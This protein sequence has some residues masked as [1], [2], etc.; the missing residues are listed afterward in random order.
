MAGRSMLR[1][2][3][4]LMPKITTYWSSSKMEQTKHTL[5]DWHLE[6]I[7]LFQAFNKKYFNQYILPTK[8]IAY[9]NK[10]AQTVTGEKLAQLA[11]HVL[12]EIKD[13]KHTFTHFTK[14]KMRDFCYE[15]SSGLAIL[16]YKDYPFVL[17]LFIENPQSFVRPYSKGFEP[18]MFFCMGG[19]MRHLTGFTRI[20]N[21]KRI[22]KKLQT[23][24]HWKKRV[25]LP[26]KWFWEPRDNQYFTIEGKNIG[27]EQAIKASLP[28]VYAVICDAIE[29]SHFPLINQ[30][31]RQECLDIARFV[32]Y[33]LD[34]H[35]PNFLLEKDTG[36]LVIIDT[37][38]FP[39]L[40]GL[41]QKLNAK[42]YIGWYIK[43]SFNAFK[44]RYCYSK[45]ARRNMQ[46]ELRDSY[47]KTS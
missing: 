25:G 1:P 31:N 40:T 11:E 15:D 6:E 37:E 8:A 2:K 32:D 30:K 9:R 38:H 7:P 41:K 14:L 21:L 3:D 13:G 23:H 5:E 12:Q 33:N 28:S 22:Q 46:R 45:K 20:S 39:T 18:T 43:L 29:A 10:P 36:K 19:T 24:P 17:K 34:P 16:K 47:Y 44:A 27:N 42:S 4:P 35:L 26:R